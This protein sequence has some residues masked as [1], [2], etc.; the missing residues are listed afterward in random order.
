[1]KALAVSVM[2]KADTRIWLCLMASIATT[3]ASDIPP[4]IQQLLGRYCLDCHDAETQ[5]GELDLERFTSIAEIEADSGVWENVLHQIEDGEMPPKKK[6][7]F[8]VGERERFTAWVRQTLDAIALANAGDPGPVVLRRLSNREYTNTIRDLT[9]VDSLDPAREFPVDGAAGEGFTNVGSALV[10]S[11]GLLTKYLD[12]AKEVASHAVILPDRIEFSP[13]NSRADWTNEKLVAIR[14]FHLRHGLP[15]GQAP[16][17]G[18]TVKNV[19]E[20]TVIP[21]EAYLRKLKTGERDGLSEKYLATLEAALQSD[22]PSVLFDPVRERFRKAKPEEMGEIAK[23][24]EQLQAPLFYFSKVGHIGKRDAPKRWQ[25]PTTPVASLQTVKFKLP[26]HRDGRTITIYLAAGDADDG[27]GDAIVWRNP[28]MTFSNSEPIPLSNLG[29]LLKEAQA[30]QDREL[31]RTAAYLGIIALAYQNG[32]PLEDMAIKRSLDPKLAIDWMQLLKLGDADLTPSGHFTDK[33]DRVGGWE[34]LKGWRR[35]NG[36]PSLLVNQSEDAISHVTFTIP[37]RAVTV[38]PTPDIDSI[39]LWKSPIEGE[40]TVHGLIADADGACG[41]GAAWKVE[42]LRAAGPDTIANGQFQNGGRN[43]FSGKTLAV[44]RGELI[45]LTVMPI[46]RNHTCDTTRISLTITEN[47]DG[48]QV[49]D[50]EK[51][52]VDRIHEGNPFGVWH[53]ADSKPKKESEPAIP[54]DSEL[55]KW[56][57]AI[58]TGE[59]SNSQAV[60]SALLKPETDSDKQIRYRVTDLQGEFRWLPE[61]AGEAEDIE[62]LAPTTLEFPMPDSLAF[63]AEFESTVELHPDKSTNET[64]AQAYASFF[65]PPNPLPL[66]FGE[67]KPLGAGKARAWP[68][69]GPPMSPERPILVREGGDAETRVLADIAEFQALFPAALTYTQIVP[70]DEDVTLTLFHRED[71]QLSRLMLDDRQAAELDRLWDELRFVSREP[72]RLS[73]VYDQL[74]QYATQG[75]DPS[76]FEP[77]RE[78][79]KTRAAAFEKRLV[80]VGPDQVAAIV[81]FAEQ[82]WRRP[83][84]EGERAELSALYD[85]LRKQDLAHEDAIRQ[86]LARVF[87]SPAFLYRGENAAP[88]SDPAPV[89]DWE[90]ATR[91]SYFLWSSTPDAELLASAAAGELRNPDVLAA[92]SRRMLS[93]PRIRRLATEFGAQWLHVRDLATLDEKSERHFPTFADLRADMQEETVLFFVDLFQNDRSVLSLLDADHS[94]VNKPLAEHYGIPI[95][96]EDWRR[97]D[98]MRDRGRGGILGF[99]S[100]LAKHSGA[101]RTSPILRGNWVYEVV[102]GEKLPKPPK[103][104]PVL[105]DEAPEGL[106]ERQLIEQHSS[107]PSCARC[108]AKLDPL[109]FALEG[110]DAIGR[111]REGADTQAT[112]E[113]GTQFT[114]I[115]GLRSY[116]LKTRRDDFSRQFC[117]KLLGY[118]LGRSVQ[119]S[120]QQ[121]LNEMQSELKANDH[122]VR[123]AIELIVQSPQFQNARGRET[124]N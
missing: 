39:V 91:L 40:V 55:G 46:D 73:E 23:M 116:L 65:V 66:S 44:K 98:G 122:R 120:D 47:R 54:P 94:F 30:K 14:E 114:G 64:T 69:A 58:L 50:L 4:P 25:L 18:T 56:R 81:E 113:D 83:L 45:R 109:G 75:A 89:S 42:R 52:I 102:L 12:A 31:A 96:G 32:Q 17:H 9:G 82:A 67:L 93:D 24:I 104:V 119:L 74:W 6:P 77:M 8:P 1:M 5:K 124:N 36:L 86:L 21:L 10:M 20:R 48:G 88:G 85:A 76:A 99:S 11:P 105:P 79:I 112:L 57:T 106:T 118:A 101:S 110:F 84:T 15:S 34:A 27:E 72:I 37:G 60:Q 28:R 70:I 78:P 26:E 29:S 62:Q 107:D 2:K 19:P 97:V 103:D 117:R 33:I 95:D 92:Q 7:Q 49:W 16:G 90:L 3:E 123:S 59:P 115:E 87:V 13:S 68:A 53:F 41:N 111:F 38:H 35:G 43:E 71:E 63:G 22:E 121:L 108:H 61:D 100:T 80:E 51:D